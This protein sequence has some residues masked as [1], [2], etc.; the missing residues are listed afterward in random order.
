MF[1]ST[2]GTKESPVQV[3][4]DALNALLATAGI[5]ALGDALVRPTSEFEATGQ[6][7]PLW[8]V[9]LLA[10]FGLGLIAAG[11]AFDNL[12]RTH[13]PW[14]VVAFGWALGTMGLVGAVYLVTARRTIMRAHPT[15]R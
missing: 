12:L 7:K 13:G 4:F 9:L 10:V 5:W 1:S 2:G 14:I 11:W 6:S 8:I 3:A 15:V